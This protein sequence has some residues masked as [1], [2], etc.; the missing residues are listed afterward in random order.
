MNL[1]TVLH[2]K[3]YSDALFSFKTTRSE[4][5]RTFRAGQFTMIG[6]GD[7]DVLRAYSIASPPDADE[8]EFLSIK[9]PGGPLTERLKDIQIGDQIEVGDRPTGTLVI[10]N[11][12]PAKRLCA[13]PLALDLLRTCRFSVTPKR[14]NDS[15]KSW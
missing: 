4:A 13:L 1:E 12:T 2:V 6:M 3:H 5:I 14:L 15:S 7:D 10:D 11:L 9:V 8:L